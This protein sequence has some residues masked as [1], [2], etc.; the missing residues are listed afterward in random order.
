MRCL[1][2]T[3]VRPL[4][5]CSLLTSPRRPRK[6]IQSGLIDCWDET[7]PADEV[8]VSQ[9]EEHEEA[10]KLPAVANHS[11]DPAE[12][13]QAKEEE[14]EEEEDQKEGTSNLRTHAKLVVRSDA[15]R[16]QL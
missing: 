7:A 5:R 6:R 11:L 12:T 13:N 10:E 1:K 4:R 9:A 3:Q 14:E 8:R 2:S 16:W 15:A